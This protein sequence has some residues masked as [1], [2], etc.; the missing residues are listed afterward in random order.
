[1]KTNEELYREREKRFND[2][3]SLKKPDR[4]P[5]VPLVAHYFPTKVK[6]VSNRDAMFEYDTFY[7][8]FKE[9]TLELDIDMALNGQGLLPGKNMQ[10]LGLNQLEWPGGKL[11]D[12]LPF[13][14]VEKEYMKADEYDEFLA[15]PDGFTM[16]RIWPRISKTL[17][18]LGQTMI[19]PLHWMSNGYLL[20]V[21]GG[22]TVGNPQMIEM[23][24]KLVELGKAAMEYNSKSGNYVSEM[25]ELGYPMSFGGMSE[26]AYDWVSDFLRGMRGIMLDMFRMPDK[27]LAT[28]D[29][30]VNMSL[31]IGIMGAQSTGNPRVFIPLHR[32]SDGFMSNEQYAKFYWPG[33]KTLITG[34]VDAGLTPVPF[35]EGDYTSRLEFLAELPKGKVAAHFDIIDRK[36]AKKIIGDTLCFWGNVPASLMVSGTPQQVKDDVKELIDIFGDN[37]GLII[38]SSISIPDE[39]KL[40]NVKAMVEA[41]HEY[42]VY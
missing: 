12:D 6:G 42:G 27:L 5:V 21:L 9:M 41:A 1:M 17:E 7:K 24:E 13:Q 19:P 11:D 37:G 35:F 29:L 25:K 38:D 10:A 16:T 34:L 4:V 20:T 28:I 26:A 32:G 18:P 14:F 15:D 8:I 40:E 39:A 31:T 30:F 33:L 3:V 22:I 23:L 2:A 36:K